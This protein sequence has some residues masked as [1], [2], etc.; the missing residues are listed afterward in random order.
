MRK[1][2]LA[3][4]V[5]GL[6]H[7]SV[8]LHQNPAF[9]SALAARRPSVCGLEAEFQT[10]WLGFCERLQELIG[11]LRTRPRPGETS[12]LRQGEARVQRGRVL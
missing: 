10:L 7:V 3:A 1:H 11:E 9:V 12:G 2:F 6:G 4:F 8:G 5:E